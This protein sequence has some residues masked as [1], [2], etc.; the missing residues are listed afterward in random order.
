[1]GVLSACITVHHLL[2]NGGQ[3]KTTDLLELEFS[4]GCDRFWVLRTEPYSSARAAKV[5]KCWTIS[6][7]PGTWVLIYHV[8]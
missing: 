1:M 2:A 7:S 5:L 6:L 8:I 4:G 3:K